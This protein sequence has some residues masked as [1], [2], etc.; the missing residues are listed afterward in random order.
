MGKSHQKGWAPVRGKRWYGYFR[1]AVLDPETNQTRTAAFQ[2]RWSEVRD[3]RLMAESWWNGAKNS[4]SKA[5]TRRPMPSCFRGGWRAEGFEQLSPSCAAQTG[6]RTGL[7]K[8]TF[9]VIRRTIAMLG[10]TKGHVKDTQGMMRH[11]KASTTTDVYMQSLEPEVRSTINS[12]HAELMGIGTTGRILG[13]GQDGR[14]ADKRTDGIRQTEHSERR[15]PTNPSP[16][17]GVIL[18]FATTMLQS[19]G[20]KGQLS[21]SNNWWT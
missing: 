2:S 20:R 11:S 10:K 7:P 1:R 19:R 16:V 9:Q 8:L 12:I 18:E 4:R 5:K 3:A 14:L 21:D 17:R 15:S 6:R 13:T